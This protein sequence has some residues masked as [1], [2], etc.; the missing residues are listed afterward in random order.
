MATSQTGTLRRPLRPLV[1][2][3]RGGANTLDDLGQQATFYTRT[4]GWTYRVL[5]HYKK[6]VLRLLSEVA[7]GTCALGDEPSY[8]NN[9]GLPHGVAVAADGGTEQALGEP[10]WLAL[11]FGPMA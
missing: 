1:R 11:I 8:R 4:L 9:A 3:W 6:E 2:L 7:F 5:V 10:S